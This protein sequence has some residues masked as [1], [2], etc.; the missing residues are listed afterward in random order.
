[1]NIYR[2]RIWVDENSIPI[3]HDGDV[4]TQDVD[5]DTWKLLQN[6]GIYN[7]WMKDILFVFDPKTRIV[8]LFCEDEDKISRFIQGVAFGSQL[9]SGNIIVN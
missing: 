5:V 4:F 6:A 2:Y 1:M 9:W 8:G 3:K 7:N